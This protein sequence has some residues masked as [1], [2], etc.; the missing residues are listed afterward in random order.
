MNVARPL[1][2]FQLVR[3]HHTKDAREAFARVYSNQMTLKPLRAGSGIDVTV[4]NCPLPQIGL[5]YTGYGT[6]VTPIFPAAGLS[7]CRSR[8]AGK[9]KSPSTPRARCSTSGAG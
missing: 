4:N 5:N 3:T 2:R 1:D 9:Q 7:R 6:A 8:C